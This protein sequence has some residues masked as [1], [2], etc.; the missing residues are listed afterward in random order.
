VRDLPGSPFVALT[1]FLQQTI[2][3]SGVPASDVGDI[4][5]GTVLTPGSCYQ[6]RSAALAAGYPEYDLYSRYPYD[7]Y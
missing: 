1:T 7:S 3:R 2:T 6:A 4:C 5:V